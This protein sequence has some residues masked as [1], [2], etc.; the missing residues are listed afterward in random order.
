MATKSYTGLKA[1]VMAK[2][3]AING[4]NGSD[5]FVEVYGS[6]FTKP[7]GYP[8]C[9]VIEKTG[10]GNILDTHRNQRE[11]QFDVV[12][13]YKITGN[14]TAETA[15]AAM[16]DAADR[17]ITAFDRDPLLLD[18]NGAAQCMWC[19]VL[20]VEFEYATQDS[21]VHRALFTVAIMDIVNR[22]A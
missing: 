21:T 16:L 8:I 15:Y 2:L 13:H 1:I 6:N 17:V 19:K 3:D 9:Y 7:E 22:Y 4:G 11:W 5:L 20:P 18:S 10:G 14:E 12:I